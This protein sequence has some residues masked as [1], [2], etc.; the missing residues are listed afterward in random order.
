V[1]TSVAVRKHGLTVAEVEEWQE[2]FVAVAR[3]RLMES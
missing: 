2:R 3:G 1:K